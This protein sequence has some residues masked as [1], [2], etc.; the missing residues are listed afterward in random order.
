MQ[1]S[2]LT[3]DIKTLVVLFPPEERYLLVCCG[4]LDFD[5]DFGEGYS[6][7][8]SGEEDHE[9]DVDDCDVSI[10]DLKR[11]QINSRRFGLDKYGSVKEFLRVLGE[12]GVNHMYSSALL[13]RT[14]H[15]T[16]LCRK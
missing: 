5:S 8:G 14:L 9:E 7:Y 12:N 1:G 11:L 6:G 3:A 2:S 16:L 10:G 13:V 15:L 4:D